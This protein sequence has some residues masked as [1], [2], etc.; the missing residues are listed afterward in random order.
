VLV[1]RKLEIEDFGPFKGKQV[2]EFPRNDGVSIIYGENMRGKTSLLNAIRFAFFGRVIGRGSQ[3]AP[4]HT[5]GNWEQA[6]AGKY[7]FSVRLE[8]DHEGESYALTRRVR[9]RLGVVQPQSDQDYATEETVERGGVVLSKADAD[10]AV[11]AIL[12]EQISRFFLFDSELLQEYEDLLRS[13]SDMGRK[14]SEAI[15]RIL[16]VPVLTRARAMLSSV[17]DVFEQRAASEAQKNTRTQQIGNQIT[18]LKETKKVLQDELTRLSIQLDGL[19]TKKTALDEDLRRRERLIALMERR[20]NIE[21]ILKEAEGRRDKAEV[22]LRSQMGG[23]WHAILRERIRTMMKQLRDRERELSFARMRSYLAEHAPDDC[24]ACLRPLTPDA[25]ATIRTAVAAQGV[26]DASLTTLQTRVDALEALGS[27]EGRGLIRVQWSAYEA[28]KVDIQIA[29]DQIAELD[30]QL[31]AIDEDEIRQARALLEQTI[32]EIDAVERGI[33]STRGKIAEIDVNSDRL[34]RRL[35]ELGGADLTGVRQRQELY[36]RLHR[37]FDESV[38]L[39]RARLRERVQTDASR[40][41]RELTTE[42][43]YAGLRINESYGLTILHRDSSEIP[44]RSAGAEHVV[45]LCLI[46]A[47]QNNAPLRGPI[48]IDSPFGRLD[49]GHTTNIIQALPNMSRQIVLFVY[50]DELPT[51]LARKELQGKLRAEW[52]L[53]R[54][55]ARHTEIVAARG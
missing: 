7:G 22:E 19:R 53:E 28:A 37:L 2:L 39:Y 41:F 13:G 8:F 6:A 20:D 23:A 17:K 54:R 32:K 31:E 11:K 12:P 18:N 44:V 10:V 50:Q 25:M 33:D 35:A 36:G 3:L 47:L 21:R 1:L 5:I 24:P 49:R 42:S 40:F 26:D 52:R 29:N 38:A 16:G 51:D 27:Q 4:L 46:G 45:A 30:K 15:E 55:T 43:D 34:L 9:P 14:I 48:V